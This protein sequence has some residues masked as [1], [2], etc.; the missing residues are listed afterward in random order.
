MDGL[1]IYEWVMRGGTFIFYY[2]L[3]LWID[4]ELSTP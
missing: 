3:W 2:K 4:N 1:R